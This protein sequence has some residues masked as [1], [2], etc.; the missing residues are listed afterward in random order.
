M[1][2][3]KKK[4]TQKNIW[5]QILKKKTFLKLTLTSVS[6]L[7]RTLGSVCSVWWN[8]IVLTVLE[9][10]ENQMASDQNPFESFKYFT[11]FP[12]KSRFWKKNKSLNNTL[13]CKLLFFK[14][15]KN[16]IKNHSSTV[17]T[18]ERH[19][20]TH[21]GWDTD[22]DNK[23][24]K[25][26]SS[27]QGR[28]EKTLI[29]FHSPWLR[30]TKARTVSRTETLLKVI[31]GSHLSFKVTFR[32]HCHK[33][34]RKVWILCVQARWKSLRCEWCSWS[35]GVSHR[36]SFTHTRVSPAADVE[37]GVERFLKEGSSGL[38]T[39]PAPLSSPL[40]SQVKHL[41][42]PYHFP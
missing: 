6:V 38:H 29:R 22:S 16:L 12:F 33:W 14:G 11:R 27:S 9:E 5:R 21:L 24:R 20:L 37:M 2:G 28:K 7:G 10:K 17:E 8:W 1:R 25:P 30:A 23:D 3:R 40:A 36:C 35:S 26:V 18:S 15:L 31:M 41:G 13:I 39:N 32:Q 42:P 19:L 34:L 4:H